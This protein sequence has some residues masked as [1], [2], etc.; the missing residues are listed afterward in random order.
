MTVEE[1]KDL[2]KKEKRNKYG[3]KK[4]VVGEITF[5]S[6][7]EANRYNELLML[8]RAGQIRNLRLQVPFELL[9]PYGGE[10]GIKYI[11]D[12][13]YIENDKG[14]VEDVKGYRTD[15]YKIKRKLFKFKYKDIDFREI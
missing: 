15:V 10:R 6:K 1:Y 4:T 2:L 3:N 9:P 12:F 8:E 14:V 5:D 13:F 11:A 7:K